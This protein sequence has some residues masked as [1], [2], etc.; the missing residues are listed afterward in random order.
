L[1]SQIP[2]TNDLNYFDFS[3]IDENIFF[4]SF[5]EL[6][7]P[8]FKIIY[9]FVIWDFSHW[10]LFVIRAA[11]ALA[12]RVRFVIW[13]SCPPYPSAVTLWRADKTL[14]GGSTNSTAP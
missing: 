11:Q 13:D 9:G 2:N 6:E 1:K 7:C 3:I 4:N 14:A 8:F 5:S 12:P 10:D